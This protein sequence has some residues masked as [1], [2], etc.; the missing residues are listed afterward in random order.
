MPLVTVCIPTYNRAQLLRQTIQS[1][2]NQ[3]FSDWTLVIS[4]DASNDNTAEVVHGF[5][6]A[7]IRYHRQSH[8]LGV[9]ANLQAVT[10]LADT[11][12]VA[13]ISDD[14]IY[15]PDHLAAALD[16][17]RAYPHAAYHACPAICFG[18]GPEKELRPVAISDRT[19]SQLYFAPADAVRFLGIDTP[20]PINTIVC[21]RDR[22]HD[23][24]FWGPPGYIN[25]DLLIMTQLMAQGGFVF[26]NQPTVRYRLHAAN[27]SNPTR[28]RRAY[29]RVVCMTWYGIRWLAHFLVKRGVCS[30]E[31]IEKHGLT[32]ASEHYAV[33]LVTALSIA[34]NTPEFCALARRVFQARTDMD[35]ASGR[36]RLARRLGFWTI[37]ASVRLSQWLVGW[38]PPA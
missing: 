31:A 32:A 15:L 2:R 7:R 38:Q 30:L 10:A 27:T 16:A 22:F 4:D 9:A 21:R 13:L 23:R 19:T 14:D 28:S 29:L 35:M 33:Q 5:G 25:V 6:D 12:F 20:G 8:N 37:P 36:F 17:L 34:D 3:T 24:L 26:G 11:E 1:V 18:V